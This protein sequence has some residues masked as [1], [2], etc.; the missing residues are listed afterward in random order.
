[1]LARRGEVTIC[2]K[3]TIEQARAHYDDLKQR[4]DKYGRSR[5]DLKILPVF[6]PIVGRTAQEARD[7]FE[8]LQE[9]IDPLVGLARLSGQMGDLSGHPLD[10]PVPEPSNP[11]LR[12]LAQAMVDR[13]RRQNLTLR[14][15][16]QSISSAR[17]IQVVGTAAQVADTMQEWMEAGVADGFHIAPTDL[18]AG[19]LD[20]V[21]LVVPEIQRRGIY[22]TEYEGKTLRENLGISTPP[23]RFAQAR[24]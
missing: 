3:D 17:G 4:M 15:L 22:R 7:K 19:L 9:L 18:P 6:T 13:A 10:G 16:Y 21:D 23:N 5:D 1:H 24:G 12:S 2:F 14:Q 8:Q 20:F 11:R